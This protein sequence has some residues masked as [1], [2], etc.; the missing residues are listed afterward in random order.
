MNILIGDIGNSVAK[1]CLVEANNFKL[2]KIFYLDS[3]KILSKKH[4][5]I[6]LKKI[7]KKKLIFKT[8]LFASVVPV[9]KN[10]LKKTLIKNYGIRL[11]EIKD[12][13]INKIVKI[14]IK[15]KKKIG[16]N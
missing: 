13:K 12:K 1:I 7:I 16:T 8:A 11:K 9:Y 6:F 3:N 4:L 10:I 5:T 15:K 14:N 2:K